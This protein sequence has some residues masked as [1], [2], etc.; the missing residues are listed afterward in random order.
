MK[1]Y[2]HFATDIVSSEKCDFFSRFWPKNRKGWS[3]DIETF[4]KEK[5]G[6]L[7]KNLDNKNFTAEALH[8]QIWFR[9]IQPI[10]EQYSW[11]ANQWRPG[12]QIF[13]N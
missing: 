5:L 12:S 6:V 7:E 11:S 1:K 4:Y 10:I 2:Q 13:L 9:E 8:A 3:N